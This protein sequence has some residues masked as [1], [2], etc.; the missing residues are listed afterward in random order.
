MTDYK[1]FLLNQDGRIH[2][3]VDFLAPT[4]E[5]ALAEARQIPEPHGFEL[6]RGDRMIAR[7]AS[8]TAETA[9]A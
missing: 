8:A 5:H 1:V 4:D 3:V 7:L 6:W 2:K 9:K